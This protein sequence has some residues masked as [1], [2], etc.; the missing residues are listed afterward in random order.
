MRIFGREPAVWLALFGALISALGAFV[1]H[2]SPTAEGALN[3]VAALVVGVITA[4]VVHD[5]ISAAVLGLIKGLFML[6]VAFGLNLTA[7]KQAVLYAL[8]AAVL[9]SFVRTQVVAPASP[10]APVVR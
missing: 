8:A 7:D 1:L 9:A 2:I 5:G 3:A 4:I 10:M 6:M